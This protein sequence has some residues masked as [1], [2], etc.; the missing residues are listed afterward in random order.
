MP[1]ENVLRCS[2]KEVSA[3]EAEKFLD[4]HPSEARRPHM[5]GRT[6]S[7]TQSALTNV[8]PGPEAGMQLQENQ[9]KQTKSNSDWPRIQQSSRSEGTRYLL[10]WL[11]LLPTR[12]FQVCIKDMT[13]PPPQFSSRC[14][15]VS[16]EQSPRGQARTITWT[17]ASLLTRGQF[18]RLPLLLSSS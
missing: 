15:S 12:G 14:G 13:S 9:S 18:Q 3:M 4:R 8:F 5:L 16:L 11:F 17:P 2:I 10:C 1:I 6:F 7:N